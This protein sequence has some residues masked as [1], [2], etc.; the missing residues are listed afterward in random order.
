VRRDEQ[1]AHEI[2]AADDS[3]DAVITNDRHTLYAVC[4]QE[5]A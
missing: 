4:R 2:G 1:S 5:R 3:D